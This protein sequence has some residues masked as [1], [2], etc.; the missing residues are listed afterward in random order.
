MTFS[1]LLLIITG[2]AATI[3]AYL[4][5]RYVQARF[6]WIHPILISAG[7]LIA[8]IVAADIPLEAYSA[9]GEWLSMLLGPATVALG[10]PIYKHREQIA[11][12]FKPIMI[13]IICGSVIGIVSVALIL[14][15]LTD[16]QEI[17]LSMLPKSVSSPISIEISKV[18]NGIPELAAVFSVCTG[19]FG[20]VFGITI[21]QKF[22][23]QDDMSIGLAMGT[24]AHGIGTARCLANSE[25][26]GSFSG[27]AMGLAGVITSILFV[28]IYMWLIP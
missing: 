12:Q 1:E 14:W 7:L 26:Q 17:I 9:G 5:A 21:L 16:V 20:S 11:K 27:L 24:A 28:P 10:V 25:E 23:F 4:L 19:L 15:L 18:L 3:G 22:G 8:I 6:P 2:I 13:S